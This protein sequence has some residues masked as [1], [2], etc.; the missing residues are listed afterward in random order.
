[1]DLNTSM[2]IGIG[3]DILQ[4]ER[5][6]AAYDRTQGRIA[7]K[8]LGPDEMLVFKHRLARNHK[9]GMA[10]LATR[11]AA[12]EAL[13]KALGTGIHDELQ[14]V[15]STNGTHIVDEDIIPSQFNWQLTGFK[16]DDL[17][18]A[19]LAYSSETRNIGFYHLK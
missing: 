19:A 1:M 15:P 9:R 18:I 3:T 5:L 12:K 8:V 7:E 17:S 11:F 10:F 14:L 6:Q 2:I 4:I 13:A 16:P